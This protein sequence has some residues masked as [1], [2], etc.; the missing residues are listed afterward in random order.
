[1]E[2]KGNMCFLKGLKDG[3]PVA[4]GYLSVGFGFGILAAAAG[5]SPLVAFAISATN[6][7]SAGQVAGV[8]VIAAMGTYIEM[9]LTQLVINIRYSLMGLSL[10]QKLAPSFNTPHRLMVSY[11]ITDEIFAVAASQEEKLTPQ[12]MYGLIIIAFC[13]W[14]GGTLL[15]AMA[16]HVLPT[17]LTDAMGIMLYG[18][19]LAVIVPAARKSLGVLV[20][21]GAAAAVSILFYYVFTSVSAGFSVIISAIAAAAL[22]ALLFPVEEKE[23]E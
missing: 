5:L 13:G 18:M 23:E 9:A 8:G 22:G 12:Y 17:A 6:L 19:F 11:G 20:V 1:M 7:T 21:I 15:G 16:G 10:S 3:I 2:L 14:T 4:L